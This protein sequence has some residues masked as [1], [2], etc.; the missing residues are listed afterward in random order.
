MASDRAPDDLPAELHINNTLRVLICSIH[1]S[2]YTNDGYKRHLLD[3]H[4]I[5]GSL[6]KSYCQIINAANLHASPNDVPQPI[7]TP[8][9][10]EG[11]KIQS[12]FGCNRCDHLSI[13]RGGIMKHIRTCQRN[14]GIQSGLEEVPAMQSLWVRSPQWFKIQSFTASEPEPCSESG[15]IHLI[16]AERDSLNKAFNQT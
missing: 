2:C 4:Q 10:I 1:N 8:P 11:L 13:N 15:D 9:A 5:K 3:L 14:L 7:N 16:G 12:G 6:L